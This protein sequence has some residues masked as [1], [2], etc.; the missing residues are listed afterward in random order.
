MKILT[1][2]KVIT[3]I[4]NEKHYLVERMPTLLTL[5]IHT[6]TEYFRHYFK[7]LFAKGDF[8]V[9]QRRDQFAHI[10]L[11]CVFA[12]SAKCYRVMWGT[13]LPVYGEDYRET[14][15][16]RSFRTQESLCV[17]LESIAQRGARMRSE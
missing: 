14:V 12:T 5:T 16:Y 3:I 13:D 4:G 17:W 6:H 15:Q 8:V 1:V 2:M 7:V 11:V 10:G 9:Y